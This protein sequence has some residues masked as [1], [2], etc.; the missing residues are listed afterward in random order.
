MNKTAQWLFLSVLGVFLVACGGGDG[1]APART[2]APVPVTSDVAPV[3]IA[4]LRFAHE[5]CTFC[6]GG[7]V[8]IEDWTKIRDMDVGDEVLTA[9]GYTRGF[10]RAIRE[11]QGVELIGLT[12]PPGVYGGSSRSWSTRETFEEIMAGQIAD[13][14]AA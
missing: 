11:Y 1:G 3:R 8:T 5:T 13:L 9:G 7:D 6:P 2:A 10:T 12:S 14:E 4:V